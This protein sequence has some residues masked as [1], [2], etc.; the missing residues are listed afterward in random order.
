MINF[1]NKSRITF[2]KIKKNLFPIENG[3][4]IKPLT[5]PPIFKLKNQSGYRYTRMREHGDIVREI[6][7]GE[8]HCHKEDLS[9]AC[10]KNPDS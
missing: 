5:T 1:T 9:I 10:S 4:R 2:P 6:Q 8:T 7:I 3:I